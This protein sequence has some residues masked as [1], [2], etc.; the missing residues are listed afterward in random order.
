MRIDRNLRMKRMLP[1]VRTTTANGQT[2]SAATYGSGGHATLGVVDTQGWRRV[3]VEVSKQAGTA[4]KLSKLYLGMQSG[5]TTL[6]ASCSPLSGY[7][8][9]IVLSAIT[10]SSVTYA[11][12]I[13]LTGYRSRKRYL[14]CKLTTST[15]S[16][17]V[18][19]RAYELE[20]EQFPP[21]TTGYTSITNVY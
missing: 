13:N 7:T 11:F 5:A 21:S 4:Q 15:T 19:V 18:E 2:I 17:N 14:N 16:G 20:G 8:S 10:T 9:G 12:D 6:W 1:S 3:R